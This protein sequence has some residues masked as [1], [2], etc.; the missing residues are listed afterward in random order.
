MAGSIK[1][2]ND[3]R[4]TVGNTVGK[5]SNADHVMLDSLVFRCLNRNDNTT[6]VLSVSI[7]SGGQNAAPK[8]N[9]TPFPKNVES[10]RLPMSLVSLG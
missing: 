4:N 10:S 6:Y 2:T 8:R 5:W 9:S 7:Q 3:G 1:R